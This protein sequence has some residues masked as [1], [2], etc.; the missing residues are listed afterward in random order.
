MN[1]VSDE[2]N[3]RLDEIDYKLDEQSIKLDTQ[4]NLLQEQ[5]TQLN[6]QNDMLV[7]I[8]D[9][10]NSLG[11]CCSGADS[12]EKGWYQISLYVEYKFKYEFYKSSCEPYLG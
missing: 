6:D 12:N 2:L 3:L 9:K 5:V 7:E 10:L 11:D 1:R 4:G 8:L